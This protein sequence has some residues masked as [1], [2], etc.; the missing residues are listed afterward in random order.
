MRRSDRPDGASDHGAVDGETQDHE[1]G[2]RLRWLEIPEHQ[3]G[4]FTTLAERLEAEPAGRERGA[5]A[6]RRHSKVITRLL[7]QPYLVPV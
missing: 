4:F 6:A 7:R 2:D 1:L 3:P 5:A